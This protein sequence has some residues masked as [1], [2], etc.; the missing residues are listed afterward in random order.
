MCNFYRTAWNADAVYYIAMTIVTVCIGVARGYTY[1][2]DRRK[3][4][5]GGANLQWKVES[6]P[7]RQSAPQRQIKSPVLRKL[8]RSGRWERLFRQVL[9]A[10][11]KKVVNF[12]RE[13]NKIAP[14]TKSWLRLW[15]SV[16]LSVRLRLSLS[17]KPSNACI[18]TR[19]KKTVHI[20]D[21]LSHTKDHL[22][23][24]YVKKNGWWG[25]T[26]STW[27]FRS[28]GSHWSEFADFEPIFSRSALISP[29]Q[30]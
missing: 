29:I 8:G 14:Q 19:R 30:P 15:P 25:A 4:F 13:E 20:L 9:R 27:Y 21:F 26:P 3:I 5:W 12:C 10:T 16:R 7:P 1:T 22:A 28:T 24:F 2:P 11:A 18:V 23:Y 17:L 6:A